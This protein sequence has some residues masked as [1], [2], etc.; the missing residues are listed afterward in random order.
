MKLLERVGHE[1]SGAQA[2]GPAFGRPAAAGGDCAAW[3]LEPKVLLFD[4][5]TS[6]L[7]PEM[8][9]EVLD[10]MQRSGQDRA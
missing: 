7:D 3:R 10:V 4:E 1:G 6:A 2:P 9:G 8:I 5:P